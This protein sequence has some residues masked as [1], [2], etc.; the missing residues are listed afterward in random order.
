MTIAQRGQVMPHGTSTIT[1]TLSG[2]TWVSAVGSD[3][4]ATTALISGLD[5]AQAEAGGC[6]TS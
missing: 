5:S 2:D 6:V 1:I 3:D 4:A